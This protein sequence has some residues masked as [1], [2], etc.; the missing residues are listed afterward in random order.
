MKRM[1]CTVLLIMASM[2]FLGRTAMAVSVSL[3]PN[4]LTVTMGDSVDVD[5]TV[6]DLGGQIVSAYDLDLLF[7]PTVLGVS[8]VTFNSV[9]GNPGVDTVNGWSV[10]SGNILDIFEVSLLSD[11]DLA[12]LQNGSSVTPVKISFQAVADGTTELSLRWDAFNDIK[13]RD[14][15]VIYPASVPEPASLLLFS[16]GLIGFGASRRWHLVKASKTH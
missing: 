1:M 12:A 7:D 9:L 13:G 16:V 3:T 11:T 14:N 8:N 2:L 4:P 10:L 15:Q 5:F 6:A